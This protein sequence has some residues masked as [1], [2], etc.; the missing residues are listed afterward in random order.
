M[1]SVI[2]DAFDRNGSTY[3]SSDSNSE[4]S[5]EMILIMNIAADMYLAEIRSAYIRQK[6]NISTNNS[7]SLL[8]Q[9]NLIIM[10]NL[11]ISN[12]YFSISFGQEDIA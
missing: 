12:Y 5:H 6:T 9:L 1:I 10:I 8:L 4:A 11:F 3:S 7:S 2:I